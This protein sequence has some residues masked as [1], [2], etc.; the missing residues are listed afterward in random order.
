MDRT[1]EEMYGHK[2]WLCWKISVQC[3]RELNFLHSDIYNCYYFTW[4][5]TYFIQLE[6][7]LINHP[8]YFWYFLGDK[9][10]IFIER[11]IPQFVTQMK[12]SQCGTKLLVTPGWKHCIRLEC[13]DRQKRSLGVGGVGRE[14][15]DSS[16]RIMIYLIGFYKS[17]RTS[18]RPASG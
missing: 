10:L 16:R 9:E 3:G 15:G 13:L 2:W 17:A 18:F 14:G 7:L 1:S 12:E 6:T 4:S 11:T 5:D 8:S